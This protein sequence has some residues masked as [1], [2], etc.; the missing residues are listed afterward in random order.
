MAGEGLAELPVGGDVPEANR[1][2]DAGGGEGAA[3]RAE[4]N[5]LDGAGVAAE[6]RNRPGP[7]RALQCGD[8][9]VS[10]LYARVRS[11][12]LETQK[13][14]DIG[15]GVELLVCGRREGERGSRR[16]CLPGIAPLHER[17]RAERRKEG[18][19]YE[20]RCTDRDHSPAFP[21]FCLSSQDGAVE[22]VTL[23]GAQGCGVGLRP[24]L[25]VVEFLTAQEQAFRPSFSL[26][27]GRLPLH[28]FEVLLEPDGVRGPHGGDEAVVGE[29]VPGLSVPFL[30][31]HE[32]R[33]DEA[34]D[35]VVV[36]TPARGLLPQNLAANPGGGDE[37]VAEPL[38]ETTLG[39]NVGVGELGETGVVVRGQRRVDIAGLLQVGHADRLRAGREL[40]PEPSADHLQLQGL[41]VDAHLVPE[42]AVG[43]LDRDSGQVLRQLRRGVG[44][45]L[46]ASVVGGLD[47]R[48][49]GGLDRE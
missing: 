44:C 1:P 24:R 43:L 39:E 20:K 3:V 5:A 19:E 14:R 4:G 42:A 7:A 41:D 23:D 9:A 10:R 27:Q 16:G 33:C 38:A 30:G 49:L 8:D 46:A 47:D 2:I 31:A 18:G 37:P 48:L 29:L 6:D 11:I 21:P 34:V 40:V 45:E 15:T 25:G 13:Q 12:R 36:E 32:V 26:P 17:P 28:G 35:R 22:Q